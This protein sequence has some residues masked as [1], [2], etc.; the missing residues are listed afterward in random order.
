ME[1]MTQ[2]ERQMYQVLQ[3]KKQ[4]VVEFLI[5]RLTIHNKDIEQCLNAHAVMV[6]L[7]DNENTYGKLVEKE[8]LT[9]LIKAACDIN[10]KDNQAY[11]LNIIINIIK[12]FPDYD[13]RIGPLA[14]EF[15]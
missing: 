3:K 1:G 2:I 4:E 13:K 11:A 6:E 12:E 14:G 8:N 15:T 5:Q 10:N 7:T 9:S